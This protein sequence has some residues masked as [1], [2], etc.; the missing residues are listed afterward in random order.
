[1]FVVVHPLTVDIRG[2]YDMFVVV[3]PLIFWRTFSTVEPEQGANLNGTKLSG[4]LSDTGRRI[5]SSRGVVW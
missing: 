3:H 4:R 5:P 1:M 2:H